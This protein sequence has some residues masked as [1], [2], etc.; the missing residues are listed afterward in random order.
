TT[1]VRLAR[2][3]TLV[4]RQKEFVVAA[5]STGARHGRVLIREILPNVLLPLVSYAFIVVAVLIVAE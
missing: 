5:K 2:A 3:N 1:Y 4:F